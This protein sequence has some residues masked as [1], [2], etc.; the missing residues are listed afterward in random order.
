MVKMWEILATASVLTATSA[1]AKDDHFYWRNVAIGAKAE[2][3]ATLNLPVYVFAGRTMADEAVRLP[4]VCNLVVLNASIFDADDSS[5]KSVLLD[6]ATKTKAKVI[7]VSGIDIGDSLNGT[8]VVS[9][10]KSASD[11][12]AQ[13]IAEKV[14]S[15]IG[16]AKP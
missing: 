10:D 1:I 9:V 7:V 4:D 8:P 12:L 5:A 13:S 11:D 2:Q 6:A 15:Q 16:C 14:R 3:M